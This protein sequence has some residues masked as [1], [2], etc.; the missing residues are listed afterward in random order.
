[1]WIRHDVHETHL[2]NC[3]RNSAGWF[4][5]DEIPRVST[6]QKKT[7]MD[8]PPRMDARLGLFVVAQ[9]WAM[10]IGRGITEEKQIMT[11]F[12]FFVPLLFGLLFFFLLLR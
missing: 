11:D 4:S 7:R 2:E 3:S 8:Y 1:M 10:S 6:L 5:C 12:L 9:S